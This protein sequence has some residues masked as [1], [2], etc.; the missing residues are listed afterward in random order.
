MHT[1][2]QEHPQCCCY[3]R[4][5]QYMNHSYN[6]HTCIHTNRNTHIP[7]AIHPSTHLAS[8]SGSDDAVS[9]QHTATHSEEGVGIGG[10]GLDAARD[11]FR[12]ALQM[13]P[14]HGGATGVLQCLI[15]CCSVLA[16]IYVSTGGAGGAVPLRSH[17]CDAVCVAVCVAVCCSV[18]QC[19]GIHICSSARC[20]WHHF[21]AMPQVREK[22][23]MCCV[24]RALFFV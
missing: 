10:S 17:R 7:V 5:H 8:G 20:R 11:T 16:F 21:M 6:Q 1:H 19:V 4:R 15:V 24:K 12:R 14:F 23:P 2:T 9:L 22:S 13:A 3:T 18:L